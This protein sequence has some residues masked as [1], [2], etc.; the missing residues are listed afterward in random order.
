MKQ[1]LSIRASQLLHQHE[2]I[3][4]LKSLFPE[5]VKQVGNVTLEGCKT[6]EVRILSTSPKL[7]EI[8]SFI[9]T[10]REQEA[11]G[12]A[13]YTIGRYLR[14]YTKD[15]LRNA[16]IVYLRIEREF[17]RA[18][19]ECGTI[20]RSLFPH[21]NLG[22]QM[23]DL[24]LDLRCAPQHKDFA[25]TIAWAEWIVSAKFVQAFV[26]GTC[27]ARSFGQSSSLRTRCKVPRSG[28]N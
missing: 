3:E 21:C 2:L 22:R 6:Y 23:S 1:Y 8:R 9:L 27:R 25:E 10:K 4:L 5:S 11:R 17:E 28:I 14:S 20:Y 7:Q 18:G 16:D 26:E 12:F 15:E 19:E 24:I 13:G